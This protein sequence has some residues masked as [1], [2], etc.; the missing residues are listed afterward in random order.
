MPSNMRRISKT[1]L[2]AAQ[3]VLLTAGLGCHELVD[4]WT[5]AT[6]SPDLV[7]T[8]SVEGAR[9]AAAEPSPNDQRT[10]YEVRPIAPQDGTVSHWPLWWQDHFEETGSADG[11]FAMTWEDYAGMPY[12]LGRFIVNTIA[13]PISATFYPP[14][15]LR[16]SDGIVTRQP[17]GAEHDPAWLPAGGSPTPP[18]VIE[19]GAVPPDVD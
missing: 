16:S 17:L 14:V 2:I 12:G 13:I 3:A 8:A 18:D 7:T 1:G 5:D 11:Q 9:T 10:D 4:P 6:I 19:I 15:P